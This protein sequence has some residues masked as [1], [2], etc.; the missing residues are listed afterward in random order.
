LEAE[1]ANLLKDFQHNLQALEQ[2]LALT[3]KAAPSRGRMFGARRAEKKHGDNVDE[4]ML[5]IVQLRIQECTLHE[6]CKLLRLVAAGV[7]AA[8]DR[9]K[10]QQHVLGQ[11]AQEFEGPS[12]WQYAP[13]AVPSAEICAEVR[14]AVACKLRER[15]GDMVRNVDE[16]FQAGILQPQGG[17]LSVCEKADAM[18]TRLLDALRAEARAE[19]LGA[20]KQIA[21]EEAILG[22]DSTAEVRGQRLR[23]CLE[24]AKA[25]FTDCGGTQ[26]LIA[27]VPAG[28]G[29]ALRDSFSQQLTPPA[30]VTTDTDA[31]LVLCYEQQGLSLAHVAA[32]LID[33]RSDIIQIANRLHT[34]MDVP[35]SQLP[36]P[37]HRT[38]PESVPG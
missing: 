11:W 2:T 35:W 20:L 4:L 14:A 5:L 18:Q 13:D 6:V 27:V 32:R 21:I 23:A 10:D 28:C 16:R 7:S 31:D 15:L 3:E 12:P 8:G 1:C 22:S 26:R 9:L 25:K 24:A 34:R 17:L 29:S 36:Q 19:V 38:L 33:G 37:G 30:T